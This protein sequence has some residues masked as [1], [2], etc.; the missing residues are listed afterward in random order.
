MELMGHMVAT[1]IVALVSVVFVLALW[2]EW[3]A[4]KHKRKVR[5]LRYLLGA[6][7]WWGKR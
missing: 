2:D 6:P 1:V 3:R 7:P 4:Y 5:D